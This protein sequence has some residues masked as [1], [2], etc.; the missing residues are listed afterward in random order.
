METR[1]RIASCQAAFSLVEVTICL[2]L[3]AVVCLGLLAAF[4]SGYLGNRASADNLSAEAMVR[5]YLEET[6]NLPFPVLV[7]IAVGSP[8]V[9]EP[10]NGLPVTL[11]LLQIQAAYRRPPFLRWDGGRAAQAPDSPVPSPLFVLIRQV[12]RV[13]THLY[14]VEIHAVRQSPRVEALRAGGGYTDF[15]QVLDFL[16]GEPFKVSLVRLRADR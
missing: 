12:T 9:G 14:Q 16:R 2:A 4:H 3:L 10:P 6:L 15:R 11:A 5:D 7:D 1:Q 8:P 13:E